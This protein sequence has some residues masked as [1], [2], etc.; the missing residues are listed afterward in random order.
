MNDLVTNGTVTQWEPLIAHITTVS[1]SFLPNAGSVWFFF[2]TTK[3][4][5]LEAPPHAN[6]PNSESRQ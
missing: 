4:Q 6:L 5:S 3:S 2:L 1:L